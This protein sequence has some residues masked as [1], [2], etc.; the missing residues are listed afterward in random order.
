M[1]EWRDDWERNGGVKR[2]IGTGA[3]ESAA[4]PLAPSSQVE[5]EEAD[6]EECENERD[7]DSDYG[8]FGDVMF[9]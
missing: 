2:V 4:G 6:P 1:G 8:S 5:E 7:D 3:G 9:W